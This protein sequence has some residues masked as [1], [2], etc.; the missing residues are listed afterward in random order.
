MS[1]N[2][3]DIGDAASR[4]VFL[5]LA[6]MA[7]AGGAGGLLNGCAS[8]PET[9]DMPEPAWLPVEPAAESTTTVASSG[10]DQPRPSN[11]RSILPRTSWAAGRPVPSLMRPMLRVRHITVHHSAGP[12]F[13]ANDRAG[14]IDRLDSIRRYHRSKEWG[15]IGYHFAID[16]VGRV[17]ECRSLRYQGAHVKDHNEGNLGIL[18]M[19]NF[20]QQQPDR[21]QLAM[22]EQF[23][24][25]MMSRFRVSRS[26]LHSHQEWGSA[27]ACPGRSLQQY[28]ASARRAGRFG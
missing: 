21:R 26:R 7:G 19:G 1:Q 14:T 10:A 24:T 16:R 5:R 2:H 27:T 25:Q 15:D 13:T 12:L 11:R 9:A 4:R 28:F 18:V 8:T 6:I 17:W 23:T 3:I 20:E 22:L